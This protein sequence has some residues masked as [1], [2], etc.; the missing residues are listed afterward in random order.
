MTEKFNTH[1]AFLYLIE[2][3]R[4]PETEEGQRLCAQLAAKTNYEPFLK[5]CIQSDTSSDLEQFRVGLLIVCKA[6]GMSDIANKA[7]LERVTLYRNLWKRGNPSL[8][9]IVLILKALGLRFSV[10]S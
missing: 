2:N 10:F 1:R 7:K 6:I 4:S 3:K 9:N 8:K 5:L